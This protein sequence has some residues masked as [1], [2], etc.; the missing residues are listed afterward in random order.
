MERHIHHSTGESGALSLRAESSA[1]MQIARHLHRSPP[2]RKMA[3]MAHGSLT[4]R[5]I[6]AI[7]AGMVLA[8]AAQGFAESRSKSRQKTELGPPPATRID[9]TPLGYVAPSRFY[10]VARLSSATLDF[11]DKDHLLFTFREGGLLQRVPS[12]PREDDDQVIC[13]VVLDIPT[14]QVVERAKWRMHDRE[15]YLW[16]IG[17][18]HFLVRQRNALYLTD[19]HLG[20][21]PYMQVDTQLQALSVAPDRKLMMVEYQKYEPPAADSNGLDATTRRPPPT[22]GDPSPPSAR[23]VSTQILMVRTQDNML[24]AKSEV[25]HAVDV[26]LLQNGFLEVLEGSRPDEWVIRNKPF[27]GQPSTIAGFKSACDPT[28][29]T[30]SDTVALAVGCIGGSNDHSVT[31]YSM[32]GSILWQDR[33]QSRYI[34]PTFEFAENGSRFAYGSL[35]VNHSIG[36]MDPFGEDDVVAQMVGVFDTDTGKLE[37]VKTATPI[38]SAGHNYALSADGSRFA[39]LRN[40]AI[41]VYDLPPAPALPPAAIAKATP[42]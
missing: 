34:W 32:N 42:K 19:S 33:W 26:P 29:T 41:E 11:I 3:R 24:I 20:L 27:S 25:G 4:T 2:A 5:S 39:I 13:A 17:D 8:V 15:R 16:A 40:D 6:A 7:L 37:L 23:P 18:G 10:L 14:G 1:I 12:D 38:L 28:V 21:R 9:V 22:L 30:L 35:E 36:T 31:A